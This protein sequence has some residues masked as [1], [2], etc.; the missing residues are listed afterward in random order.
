MKGTVLALAGEV[1]RFAFGGRVGPIP[2][3]DHCLD[4]DRQVQVRAGDPER[5]PPETGVLSSKVTV[6]V[7]G[8]SLMQSLLLGSVGRGCAGQAQRRRLAENR[9]LRQRTPSTAF[10]SVPRSRASVGSRPR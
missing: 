3:M 1:D 7:A 2:A 4:G 10:R 5:F 9:E 8:V 6:N